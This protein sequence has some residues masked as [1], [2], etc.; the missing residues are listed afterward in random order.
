M[1][2][3]IIFL[4]VVMFIL[5]GCTG[6]QTTTAGGT[7]FIG[8]TDA[9]EFDF[10]EGAPPAEVYDKGEFPFEIS[11]YVALPSLYLQYYPL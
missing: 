2:K 11:C 7:A 6:D 9:I 10:L 3:N 8:G 4:I 1:N 5:S